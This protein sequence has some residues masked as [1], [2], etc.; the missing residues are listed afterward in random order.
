MCEHT[1]VCTCVCTTHTHTH[2]IQSP[3]CVSQL[4]LSMR[5]SLE[6][7]WLYPVLHHWT[8]PLSLS[9]H[10]L[11]INSFSEGGCDLLLILYSLNFRWLNDKHNY[12]GL[13]RKESSK[14]LVDVFQNSSIIC[15]NL[16]LVSVF[17][18]VSVPRHF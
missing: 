6:Y 1:H 8:N 4:L 11:I 18:N 12:F 9:Q 15:F 2:T 16:V 3:I 14:T 5:P 17:S 13:H 10:L 7:T